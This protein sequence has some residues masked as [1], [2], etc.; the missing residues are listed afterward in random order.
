MKEGKTGDPSRDPPKESDD[1]RF[2]LWPPPASVQKDPGVE[3]LGSWG[4]ASVDRLYT[5]RNSRWVIITWGGK[6]VL[7][8]GPVPGWGVSAI[9]FSS[10]EKTDETLSS[11][12]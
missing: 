3:D 12:D 1:A 2:T 5:W 4:K 6:G 11:W 8:H 7:I 10:L 9:K